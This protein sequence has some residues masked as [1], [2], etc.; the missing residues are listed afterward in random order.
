[1]KSKYESAKIGAQGDPPKVCRQTG[2]V[3]SGASL[4]S[5]DESF[6]S[7]N[8][9]VNSSYMHLNANLRNSVFSAHR[10]SAFFT[11]LD[12]GALFQ[13]PDR[14]LFFQGAQKNAF[15]PGRFFSRAQK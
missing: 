14:A 10:S 7:Q 2:D 1:M 11:P 6:K 12:P 8:S 4:S 5:F 15:F 9:S 3:Q 13:R